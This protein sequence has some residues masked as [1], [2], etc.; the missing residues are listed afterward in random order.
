LLQLVAQRCNKPLLIVRKE[1]KAY[2][3]KKLVEGKFKSGDRVVIIDDV[4]TTGASIKE[5]CR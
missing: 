2:G 5:V 1:A 3:T 4:I